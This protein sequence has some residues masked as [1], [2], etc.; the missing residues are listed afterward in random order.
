MTDS[1]KQSRSTAALRTPGMIQ[2]MLLLSTS[3]LAVIV[4]TVLGPSVP[5]MQR[6]FAAIAGVD[7]LVPISV[8]VPMLVMA[9]VSILAGAAG[10][11][12]GR[13]RI[14]VWGLVCYGVVGT[15]PLWLS[16]LYDIIGSRFL[17]GILDAMIVTSGTV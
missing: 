1:F 2:A 10:D 9:V 7:Y 12:L 5:Q 17:L 14:L 6:H 13:K 3:S 8:T 16:S 11:R 4:T 15:A